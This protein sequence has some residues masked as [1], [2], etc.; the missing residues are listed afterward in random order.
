MNVQ[1]T[2]EIQMTKNYDNIVFQLILPFK[3]LN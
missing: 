2:K 1:F 3:K